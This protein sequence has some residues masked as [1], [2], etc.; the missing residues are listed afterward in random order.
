MR[1][2]RNEKP[3][4]SVS[5]HGLTIA[6]SLC[7]LIEREILPGTG[8]APE[9][10]WAGL[11]RLVTEFGPRNRDLLARR[12]ELQ[13]KLDDYHRTR[14]GRLHDAREYRTYIEDIGYL[15]PEGPDFEIETRTATLDAEVM[16]AGPQLVVPVNN[17]RY[18]LNATNARWGSLY[19]ALYGTDMIPE[20]DGC[21]REI[22]SGSAGAESRTTYNPERGKRVVRFA[23]DFLDQ[24]LPLAGVGHDRATA[25][26]FEPRAGLRVH[27]S[28][29]RRI[30]LARPEQLRGWRTDVTLHAFLFE[31]NGLH[32]E[33]QI[34]REHPVGAAH[35]A[36]VC[37]VVL[38]A[39][40]TTIQDCE[41]SVAAVDAQDKVL[42]YRNWLGLMRGDLEITFEKNGRRSTRRMNPDRRYTAPDGAEFVLPGRSL[43]FVR[44][45]GQHMYTGVVRDETGADI[46]EALLDALVTPLAAL[47]DLN[48]S[49]AFVNS[50][51]GSVY[52]VKPKLHGPDEAAL[53]N[54]L[55][56]VVEDI[57]G[58]A[59][60]TIKIGLM[61]EE[62]RT[63]VNLKE[64]IR[65]LRERIVFINTGFLDRT[66]D[67]IHTNMHAGPVPRKAD[68][69]NA[70]WL[71]AYENNNVDVGLACGLGGRAQIGKGMWAQPDAMRAMFAAKITHPDSGANCAWVPSPTAAVL[72]ALHY[73]QVNVQ[74]RQIARRERGR[75]PNLLQEILT[76]A[77]LQATLTPE[78]IEAELA[79]N[80]QSILGYVVRWV[81]QGVGC[82]K[83]P[84]LNGVELMEDRATLRISSQHVANWL[85]HGM[86]TED[87]VRASMRRIAR[88]V[89]YQNANDPQ[90]R[91]LCDQPDENVAYQAA[92]A[93]VFR[94]GS[95][96]SGYTE[97]ILSAA[98]LQAK[99]PGSRIVR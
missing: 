2:E 24:V 40:L 91:A 95:E 97:K 79:N 52:V 50:R 72:H 31:H 55:F 20:T 9:R 80:L 87:Q 78:E 35:P 33:L 13:R 73:H 23:A 7:D 45:V 36:G 60:G 70:T 3:E 42:V 59:R 76:P 62:R 41:D 10:L 47:Y 30:P 69:K 53:V 5:R 56:G 86:V 88:I 66:G 38:E 29:G 98:R 75:D 16:A 54:D 64:C 18:A 15:V 61:D 11:R 71:A 57:L 48:R 37:D 17:A 34:D 6:G 25:Y 21:E 46:P 4:E 99:A 22:K 92:L 49:G 93:L 65:A 58:L 96:P 8:I 89:D 51:A 27:L 81:D 74:E 67:E 77:I 28:D 83:V 19:D 84:D 94:D 85:L 1:P 82:S 12:D 39:A 68:L 14:R 32:F 26:V 43:L 90:Y 44:N 63:S